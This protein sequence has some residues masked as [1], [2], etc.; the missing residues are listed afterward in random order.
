MHL[1]AGEHVRLAWSLCQFLDEVLS[2]AKRAR[3]VDKDCSVAG[4]DS[5]KKDLELLMGGYSHT[6]SD[7]QLSVLQKEV[8]ALLGP[9]CGFMIE[10]GTGKRDAWGASPE[11]IGFS[12]T[13]LDRL[14]ISLSGYALTTSASV[15]FQPGRGT[16]VEYSVVGP[17]TIAAEK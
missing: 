7:R 13:F 17:M 15:F 8:S 9:P 1:N 6:Y 2:V 12:Y 10:G 3:I 5:R 11:T 16:M 14:R 4:G